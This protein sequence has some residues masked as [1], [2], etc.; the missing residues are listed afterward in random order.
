MAPTATWMKGAMPTF[1]GCMYLCC[2]R[3]KAR[4]REM[5]YILGVKKGNNLVYIP[6][7]KPPAIPDGVKLRRPIQAP[8]SPNFTLARATSAENENDMECYNRKRNKM[9]WRRH[10]VQSLLLDKS[11]KE[12]NLW[13][14][15]SYVCRR[16]EPDRRAHGLWDC[17][18]QDSLQIPFFRSKLF[19]QR[20]A[21]NRQR[22]QSETRSP[23]LSACRINLTVFK[24]F[25]KIL[26]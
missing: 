3:Q 10:L 22:W 16:S 5:Y 21:R 24:T 4:T 15:Y 13:S 1:L 23:A 8:S 19:F 12:S 9:E 6:R 11:R 17:N 25:I 2:Q 20:R 18:R 14:K 7:L 26:I